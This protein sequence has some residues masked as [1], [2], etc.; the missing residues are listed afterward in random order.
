MLY[1]LPQASGCVKTV[2]VGVLPP[3]F[4]PSTA[5]LLHFDVWHQPHRH[6]PREGEMGKGY[7][8]EPT[9]EA[10]KAGVCASHFSSISQY[11]PHARSL[12]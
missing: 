11:G 10:G 4:S 1:V 7:Q 6:V 2:E 9:R 5:W 8:I 3:E 12:K